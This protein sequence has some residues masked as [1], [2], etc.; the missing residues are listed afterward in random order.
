M[1]YPAWYIH[2]AEQDIPAMKVAIA[3]LLLLLCAGCQY[4]SYQ[5]SC[6]DNPQ[7]AQCDGSHQVEGHRR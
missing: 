2:L 3:A 4:F 7:Q 6:T 1:T 5:E